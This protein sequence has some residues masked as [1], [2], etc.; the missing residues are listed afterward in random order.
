[1][2]EIP[3][4]Q[5]RYQFS[6]KGGT[7]PAP[8]SATI[9]QLQKAADKAFAKGN[10]NLGTAINN[11]RVAVESGDRRLDVDGD[12]K[13]TI[14][15]ASHP[16][17]NPTKK[18]DELTAFSQ[19][20][21]TTQNNMNEYLDNS[22]FGTIPLEQPS[23]PQTPIA[24]LLTQYPALPCEPYNLHGTS[25]LT[26]Q[27]QTNNANPLLALLMSRGLNLNVINNFQ[28]SSFG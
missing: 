8:A 22:D 12:R 18:I 15:N 23:L 1:M 19:I 11:L 14:S 16:S 9:K 4:K 10:I 26:P 21:G 28:R 20:A 17:F 27:Y 13:L 5:R 6:H 7:V 24:P 3:I 25:G 2:A